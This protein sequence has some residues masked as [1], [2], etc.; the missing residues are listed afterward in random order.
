MSSYLAKISKV[1]RNGMTKVG[2]ALIKI[3]DRENDGRVADRQRSDALMDGSTDDV[4]SKEL[5]LRA[6]RERLVLSC[7]DSVCKRKI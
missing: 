5:G 3:S 4:M 2:W 1:P 6:P 7:G